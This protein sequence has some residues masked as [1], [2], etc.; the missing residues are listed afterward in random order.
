VPDSARHST[1]QFLTQRQTVPVTVL[2]TVPVTVPDSTKQCLTQRQTVPVTVLDTVPDSARHSHLYR[3]IP[4][5]SLI[6]TWRSTHIKYTYFR[7][8]V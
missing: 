7:K 5:V 4:G 2:D 8:D 3:S 6:L 1:K